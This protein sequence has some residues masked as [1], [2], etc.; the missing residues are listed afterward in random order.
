MHQATRRS[1]ERSLRRPYATDPRKQGESL[2][3]PEG[4]A[5]DQERQ[6]CRRQQS[7]RAAREI[8]LP[9]R[10]DPSHKVRRLAC[11]P[12]PPVMPSQRSRAFCR[13]A[14]PE[15]LRRAG[16][17]GALRIWRLR[18]GGAG[19]GRPRVPGRDRRQVHRLGD[20]PGCPPLQPF[21]SPSVPTRT[22]PVFA[23]RS[24]T[25]LLSTCFPKLLR[26]VTRRTLLPP[27][28]A[29][30]R[31]QRARGEQ[32]APLGAGGDAC[33]IPPRPH[34]P[35]PPAPPAPPAQISTRSR[36]VLVKF[37]KRL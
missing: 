27:G 15:G 23:A 36:P 8:Q 4:D 18:A 3:G 1:S 19:P 31:P 5:A 17:R 21:A 13:G 16:R 30:C 32:A 22:A 26:V 35:A 28:A 33:G 14:T 10:D 29:P 9:K 12:G 24:C 20:R 37:F 11:K 2:Q 34:A 6:P 7:D 25:R